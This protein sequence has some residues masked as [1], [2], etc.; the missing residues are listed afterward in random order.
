MG[1]QGSDAN[2]ALDVEVHG[3]EFDGRNAEHLARHGLTEEVV[4]DV[5]AG[6]PR[7]F[8]N[9]PERPAT[10]LLVGA[11]STGRHWTVA[12]LL[13][14]SATYTWRP[15]TGWPST[16]KEIKAYEKAVGRS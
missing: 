14:D 8:P 4:W 16:R 5:W 13:V 11:D 1:G 7:A 15:I 2:D 9:R 3:F 10:H 6:D 12:I